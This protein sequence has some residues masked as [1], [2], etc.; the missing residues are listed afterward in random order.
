MVKIR[1][2]SGVYVLE[3]TSVLKGT[4]NDVWLFFSRPEN[5]ATITP[6]DMDFKITS[7]VS[8]DMYQGQ[9]ITYK[10][11]VFNWFKLNWVTEISN[12][13]K[14][15]LFVDEQ[16]HGPYKMWRH[17]HQF[18]EATNGVKVFD[19]VVYQVP[20]GWIGRLLNTLLIKRKLISIFS[21]RQAAIENKFNH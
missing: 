7:G 10:L 15:K 12:L 13:I 9:V 1:Y 20:F 5:L 8:R 4:L 21:Y 2:I 6:A 11:S 19:K 18:Q 14:G 16:I 17:Q 3:S